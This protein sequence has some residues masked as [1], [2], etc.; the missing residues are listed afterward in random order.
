MT[1]AVEEVEEVSSHARAAAANTDK[2]HASSPRRRLLAA[3]LE[4]QRRHMAES[5]EPKTG[6]DDA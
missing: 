6:L 4:A 1:E 5:A 2:A 3:T